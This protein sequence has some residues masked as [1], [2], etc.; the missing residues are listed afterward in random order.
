RSGT[1]PPGGRG[2]KGRPAPRAGDA[3]GPARHQPVPRRPAR[4][5]AGTARRRAQGRRR[6]AAGPAGPG[7]PGRGRRRRRGL[8]RPPCLPPPPR[9]SRRSRR[10]PLLRVGAADVL[11]D[12]PLEEVTRDL[13]AVADAAVSVALRIALRQVA[14]RWG[15]PR[16]ATGRPARVTVFAFGKLGGEE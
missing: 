8:G 6:P 3:A 1:P 4:H 7:T 14:Q 16:T 11:R 9:P 2:E 15:E 5:P 12:R 10:R 13:S